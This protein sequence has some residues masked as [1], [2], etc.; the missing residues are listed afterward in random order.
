[1]FSKIICALDGSK[2][3]IFVIADFDSHISAPIIEFEKWQNLVSLSG[4]CFFVVKYNK[5]RHARC[6]APAA[7]VRSWGQNTN[8]EC[9][10]N[11]N[12]LE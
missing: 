12:T 4:E 7:G 2:Y 11:M 8:T 1:M 6:F 9:K 10:Y 3:G 5:P